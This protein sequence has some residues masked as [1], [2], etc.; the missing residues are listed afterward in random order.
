MKRENEMKS[1]D[2]DIA[3]WYIGRYVR[4]A[5]VSAFNTAAKYPEEPLSVK[6]ERERQMT[7]KDHAAR[8]RAFVEHNRRKGGE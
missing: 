4:E 8:F 1:S 2:F 3:A 6:A 5:V 7:A